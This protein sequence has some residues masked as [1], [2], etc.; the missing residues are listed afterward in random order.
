MTIDYYGAPSYGCDT[1]VTMSSKRSVA[2]ICCC[3]ERPMYSARRSRA[4]APNLQIVESR[5]GRSVSA[6]CERHFGDKST[7]GCGCQERNRQRMSR[8]NIEPRS[9]SWVA[10]PWSTESSADHSI[11]WRPLRGRVAARATVIGATSD[12]DRR[13]LKRRTPRVGRQPRIER[14][15]LVQSS[16]AYV[17]QRTRSEK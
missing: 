5:R 2:E 9:D 8:I 11:S 6:Q 7:G 10:I 4:G 13:S 15:P 3:T 14:L 16:S 12:I 1:F 17:F